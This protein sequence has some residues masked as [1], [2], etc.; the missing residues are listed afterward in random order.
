MRTGEFP[1]CW[2]GVD[3]DSENHRSHLAF[4]SAATGECPKGTVAVP[5]LR[6]TLAY[7]VAPGRTY[8]IDS[9][10]AEGRKAVTD[11]FDF[12]NVMPD[13]LMREV[14]ARING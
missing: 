1:S 12:V 8:A 2:N 5:R 7:A 13:S 9:F 11:H 6:I 10:P 4:P 14:V 3:T